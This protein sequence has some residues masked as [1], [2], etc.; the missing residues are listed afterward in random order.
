[1]QAQ[2][3]S[4]MLLGDR[5]HCVVPSL[6]AQHVGCREDPGLREQG[7]TPKPFVV[8]HPRGV[9]HHYQGLPWKEARLSIPAPDDSLDKVWQRAGGLTTHCKEKEEMGTR[10]RDWSDQPCAKSHQKKFTSHP[11]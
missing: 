7:P 3:D 10:D 8:W 5:Y 2:E 11:L 1:M 9:L 4:D 6:G